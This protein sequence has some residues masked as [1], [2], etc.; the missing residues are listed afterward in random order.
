MT[1]PSCGTTNRPGRKFCLECGSALDAACS[2][3]GA[4]VEAGAKFCGEC[5]ARTGGT[6]TTGEPLAAPHAS[7]HE[8][9]TE[10]RLVSVLFADLVGFTSLAEGRDAEA[11]RDLLSRYFDVATEVVGRYG[12]SVEKFI[13]DAVMAVWGTPVARE[14]DAER[15]VRAA[16]ELVDAVRTLG[17]E[18]ELALAARAG[19]LTGEAAVNLGARN[20]GMVAGDLVNTAARLQSVAPEGTVLVGEATRTAA[21]GAIVFEEAGPQVLKGKVAPVAAFRAVRVVAGV[22]GR[23]RSD[24]LE[25]PFVGRETEYR[26]LRQLFH[27]TGRDRKARLAS[28]TGQAGIGKSRLAWEFSKYADGVIETVWW[29]QGRCPAYGEGVTFWALGEM[30]RR[31]AGLAEGDDEATTRDRI[32]ATL[33]EWVPDPAERAFV[34]PCL[35]ALLGVAEPPSGGRER[36]FAGWRT[37]FERIADRGTVALVLED[38]HWADDGLLDFLE[39][40][41]E[42]SRSFPIFVLTLARP[43]LLDRRPTWGASRN[44]N[45]LALGPLAADEMQALLAGMAPGLPEGAVRTILERADGIPLYAVETIRTL[46]ADG[47]LVERDGVYVAAGDLG[48]LEV[49]A[50]LQAL[51]A[52]RIDALDPAARSLVADAAVLGQTFAVP[53]LAAVAGAPVDELGPRLRDLVRREIFELDTDPRSPERGQ[54]GFVQAL[55]REVAYARLARRDRRERHLAAARFFEGLGDDELAGALATHYLAAYRAVPDGPEG[56]ALAAQA[57]VSLRAAADRAYA[58]GAPGQA[59]AHL[60][61]LLELEPDERE[62]AALRERA[63]AIADDSGRHEA[64]IVHF[65]AARE[66][67]EALGDRAAAAGA[68]AGLGR[69]LVGT[70]RWDEAFELLA[71]AREAYGE[72]AATAGGVRLGAAL[73]ALYSKRNEDEAAIAEADGALVAAERL[74]L[75]PVIVD[76]LVT[77]GTSMGTVARYHEAMA[78]VEGA[79]RLAERHGLVPQAVR[80]ASMRSLITMD[81]DPRAAFDGGVQALATARRYGFL[82]S[83]VNLVGNS[84]EFGLRLGEWAWAVAAIDELLEADLEPYDRVVTLAQRMTFAIMTGRASEIERTELEEAFARRPEPTSWAAADLRLWHAIATGDDKRARDLAMEMARSDP[85]NAPALYERAAIGASRLGDLAALDVIVTEFQ[86]LG[87]Q[88]RTMAATGAFIAALCTGADPS[89]EPEARTAVFRAAAT[90]WRELDCDFTVAMLQLEATR[91]LGPATREG[92]EAA[93]EARRTFDRLGAVPFLARLDALEELVRA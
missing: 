79:A 80:A 1:C 62:A 49:P 46:V 73:A 57:R 87:R 5:G 44:A 84:A 86:A 63:G 10:R 83:A 23:E 26:L 19:V 56:Q 28:L 90:A 9:S 27:A 15:A 33:D 2:S 35:L 13:G 17:A 3:C 72:V 21:S 89:A 92:R 74:E 20:Q 29:H 18:Q 11:V 88:G 30:V 22:G 37:F 40:L 85:L 93:A 38:L 68:V 66:A 61:E 12:G 48:D 7:P 53:A 76:L 32:A 81:D 52:A 69:A 78:L 67:W 8:P 36:L 58:L 45:A 75:V 39:H 82:S 25:P 14:D 50:T 16:L 6:A 54:Y 41:L 34:E 51:I 55:I 47:R 24:I 64:A 31:R 42:W 70:G 71:P 65:R 91:V 60:D 59:L 77:K 43:E 4:P